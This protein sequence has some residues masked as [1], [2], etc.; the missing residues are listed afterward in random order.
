M[1]RTLTADEK[2]A[3]LLRDNSV[4]PENVICAYRGGMCGDEMPFSAASKAANQFIGDCQQMWAGRSD[5]G[6]A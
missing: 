4:R 5:A 6:R 2:M 1:T 3:I